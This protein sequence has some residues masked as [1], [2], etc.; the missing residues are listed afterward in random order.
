MSDTYM[1]VEQVAQLLNS[2]ISF[3]HHSWPAW[4]EFGVKPMRLNGH[5]KG[6]LMFKRSQIVSMVEK[7]WVVK[8]AA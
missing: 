7:E 4:I 5:H 8:A 2:K 1:T 6:R 3:V